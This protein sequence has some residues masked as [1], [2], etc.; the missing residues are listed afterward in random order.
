MQRDDLF[1]KVEREL[2]N[3]PRNLRKYTEIYEDILH[4]THIP[5]GDS[6]NAS[7]KSDMTASKATKLAKLEEKTWVKW[8]RLIQNMLNNMDLE[9]KELVRLKYFTKVRQV[10]LIAE[11]L[12]ISEPQFYNHRRAI[13][14]AIK[15]SALERGLIKRKDG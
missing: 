7:Y 12:H 13:V 15:M 2:Y 1:R 9:E 5:D 8:I 4:G 3:Y 14:Y 10:S 11:E 6:R